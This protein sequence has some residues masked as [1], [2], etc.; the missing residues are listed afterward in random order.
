[1]DDREAK[2]VLPSSSD[3]LH[4]RRRLPYSITTMAVSGFLIFAAIGYFGLYY[5]SKPGTKPSDV[6]R[7]TIATDKPKIE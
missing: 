2:R 6:A 5:K 1:M 4:Q 3:V 7:A